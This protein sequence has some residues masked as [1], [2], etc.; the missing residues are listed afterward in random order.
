MNKEEYLD[1]ILE[2][3]LENEIP[4]GT[5]IDSNGMGSVLYCHNKL[6]TVGGIR[7]LIFNQC[8]NHNKV[9]LSVIDS[10][11][12]LERALE[13]L[14]GEI[15]DFNEPGVGIHFSFPI[16]NVTGLAQT[17]KYEE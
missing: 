1:E 16:D 15:V 5:I 9:I 8:R 13:L 11:Q 3:F 17:S 4:G 12:K 6:P 14:Q 2:S 10:E 7:Q